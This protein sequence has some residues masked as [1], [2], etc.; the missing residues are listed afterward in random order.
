MFPNHIL[1]V[2]NNHQG[3][4]AHGK[5]IIDAVATAGAESVKF[6]YRD[7]SILHPELKT[8][9]HD[10]F[11]ETN[12][13]YAE[14][15]E[16]IDHARGLGLVPI[17]TPFDEKSVDMCIAHDVPILKVASCSA[18]DWPLLEKMAAAGKPIIASTGGQDLAGIDNLYYFLKHRGVDFAL[19]HCIAEYPTPMD[20][21]NLGMIDKMR[22]RYDVPIGYSGHEDGYEIGMLAVAKG[23]VIL[24]RHIALPTETIKI[25]A[26]SLDPGGVN[27]WVEKCNAARAACGNQPFSQAERDGL[28]ELKRGAY[29][30]DGETR[31]C[32][33][34]TDIS[35]GEHFSTLDQTTK[36]TR[37][38]IHEYEGMFREADIPL[39]G[40]KELS[41][42]YGLENFRQKGAFLV[43]VVN[44][45][46]CKKLIALLPG[47]VHPSHS[48]SVKDETFQVLWGWMSVTLEG[49]EHHLNQGDLLHVPRASQ[50]SFSAPDGCIFEEISTE[51]V[52]GDSHYEDADISGM[53]PMK[54][55]TL[56]D[57]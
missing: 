50:H 20:H 22:R 36:Q 45:E 51:S 30:I 14:R 39:R 10:R 25:N 5:A 32:M 49:Q 17:V 54:R 29:E 46:Y 21:A 43:T 26:Y 57:E 40:Q 18:D 3:S 34:M 53:D 23:A 55:K 24:E 11:H 28:K 33:P 56:L 19:M 4:V 27:I 15:L 9:H 13:S 44:R 47:Q 48:H 2:A 31:Y 35:A 38:Y 7:L 52:R 16:L 37:M 41:H 12:L 1:D 42:H 8:K 6:Q